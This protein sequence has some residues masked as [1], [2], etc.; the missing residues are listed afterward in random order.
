VRRR[1]SALV[2]VPGLLL[3]ACSLPLELGVLAHELHPLAEIAVL[4]ELLT[5]LH[6]LLAG[7]HQ[8]A[9]GVSK[10]LVLVAGRAAVAA[11]ILA[12]VMMAVV[13][14]VE[15][16]VEIELRLRSSRTHQIHRRKLQARLDSQRGI[17]HRLFLLWSFRRG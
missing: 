1:R 16:C 13:M 8:A 4:H 15:G 9:G 7:L 14:P 6:E 3:E 2:T 11:L 17:A 5:L 10:L 12:T